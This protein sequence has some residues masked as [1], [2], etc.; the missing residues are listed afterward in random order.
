MHESRY[1]NSINLALNY[2]VVLLA[3]FLPI[4]REGVSM[5]AP[6]VIVLWIVE[7]GYRY[8]GD[9][10][11]AVGLARAVLLFILLNL[12]SLLWSEHPETGFFYVSKY[13]HLLLVPAIATAIRPRFVG[14][15]IAAFLCGIGASLVWSYGIF[16]GIIHYGKGYPENAAPTMPHLE[17]SM[18]L[19]FA[20]LL[21]L[22]RIVC[23]PMD[24][25]LRLAWIG[26]LVVV[27]VGLLINFGRSGQ[28]AF[29]ATLL[30]YLIVKLRTWRRTRLA[31][32]S[33]GVALLMLTAFLAVPLFKV[34]VLAAAEEI[35]EGIIE[36]RYDTNQGK[37][38]AG[39]IV[40]SEVFL[41]HPLIGAGVADNMVEF[42]RLLSTKY[43]QLVEAIYWFPH[44]HNQ[45]LQVATELG[46]L[47]ILVLLNIFL[48]LFRVRPPDGEMR[49]LAVIL[50]CVFLFGFIG[51]PFFHKQ[52]PL[53]LFALMAGLIGAG[54]ESPHCCPPT[55]APDSSS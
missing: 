4:Y 3:L 49:D 2:C 9:R 29:F 16:F 44:L 26:F 35:S 18:F 42:R 50:G 27:W 11:L 30:V 54:R 39:M 38:I 37:R 15:A 48:Q 5:V 8:K 14:P 17:F 33:L 25:R 20:S 19:A 55:P 13:R 41:E 1:Y 34:R 36:H 21:I 28:F 47:G 53:V 45:Y 51:D 31:I 24:G 23:R 52:L 10:M 6:V 22:N 12:V 43:E 7:G 46:L 32:A 40:A